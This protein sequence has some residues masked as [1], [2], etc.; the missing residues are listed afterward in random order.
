MKKILTFVASFFIASVVLFCGCNFFRGDAGA[1]GANGLDGRDGKDGTSVSIYDA[2]E[3]AKTIEGNENLT[4]DEF[5]KIYLNYS[6]DEISA[7]VSYQASIN[8]SLMSAVTILTRF[9]YRSGGGY[10]GSTYTY[11]AY[12]GSGVVLWIDKTAGD[13]YFV[14]NCHVIYDD[15]SSDSYGISGDIRLYFYG[16][17]VEGVNYTFANDYSAIYDTGFGM[18]AEVIGASISND[19]ALLKVTGS[20]VIRRSNAVAATFADE[21]DVFLGETVYAIGNAS[22]EGMSVADGVISKD[23]EYISLN[24]TSSTNGASSYRV[25]RTTAPIN[26]GNSGGGLFNANGE[27]VGI[28][29]AKDDESDVDNMGY[30]LPGNLVKR[31]LKLMY[32]SYN[33]TFSMG[34]NKAYLGVETTVTDSYATFDAERGLAVITEVVKVKTASDFPA[35]GNLQV[36]DVF[37]NVR[38]VASNGTEKENLAITR[39]YHLRDVLFAVRSGDTVY[40]TVERNG[41][42]KDVA[43]TFNSSYFKAFK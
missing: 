12:T 26:H 20:D 36:G 6:S 10:Y 11:K 5:L 3:A 37:K 40:I 8:R 18:E 38:I 9:K 14:T 27:I 4:L 17:D 22:A 1:D 33:G 32:D 31:L 19:I 7:A 21:E 30:A 16:Q 42:D 29:N 24:L 25:M 41:V 28:V 39:E 35:K 34:G 23:S 2:Y 13:A 43:I 15:T